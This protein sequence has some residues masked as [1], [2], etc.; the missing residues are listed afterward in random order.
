MDS[1]FQKRLTF[2]YSKEESAWRFCH[3]KLKK[4]YPYAQYPGLLECCRK[5]GVDPARVQALFLTHA[6]P[7]HAGGLDIRQENA[8]Q[9]ARVYMGELEENYLTNTWHR[10]QIGPFDEAAPYDC[11]EEREE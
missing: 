2:F 7:D 10:K 1:D 9:N 4:A 8:F 6:D 5:I 11:F 3:G